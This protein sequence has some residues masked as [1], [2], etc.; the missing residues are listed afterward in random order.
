MDGG[1]LSLLVL[2]SLAV[3]AWFDTRAAGEAA[4]AQARETCRRQE[5]QFLDDS[6]AMRRL[7]IGRNARGRLCLRRTYQFDY[8]EDGSTRCQGFVIMLGNQLESIGL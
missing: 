1:T 5:L 6:V 7:G 3:W 2:L 4:V 8:T